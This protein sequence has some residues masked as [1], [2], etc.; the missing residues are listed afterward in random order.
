MRLL[1]L[2]CGQLVGA[3]AEIAQQL[4]NEQVAGHDHRPLRVPAHHADCLALRQTLAQFGAA[5]LDLGKALL[6]FF[7]FAEG[8]GVGHVGL[9]PVLEGIA[10]GHH[11]GRHQAQFGVQIA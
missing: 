2:G 11:G 7:L 3:Q 4:A 5:F 6:A 8:L 9:A 1:R 10:G